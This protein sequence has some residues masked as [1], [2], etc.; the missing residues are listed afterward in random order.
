MNGDSK[1]G[2]SRFDPNFTQNVINAMGPKTSPRMREIM[3]SLTRH[4]H[5]FAREVEL[6]VDE[7]A[8][9][10]QL[11][12]WAGQMSNDRR[13]EGQLVCDVVGLETLVDEITYKKAAEAADLATQS[14]ILGPFF[15]TDHTI[16]KKGESIST[17]TPEDAEVVYLY[18]RVVDATTKKPLAN[19]SVDVWEASTN[20][21]YEQQD[22]NQ[23]KSNL[24]GKFYTDENGEYG[25]Y[26]LRPTPY[27]IPYD[28][29]AGKLLQLLDRHP[30]RPAHIHFIV[31]AEGYKP[32]TT[33]IFDKDSK[34]LD[35]DSVFAVKDSLI[36]EFVARQGDEKAKKELKYDILMAPL[37]SKGESGEA[38]V[39]EGMGR[40]F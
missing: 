4:L 22:E 7:W 10:V 29:P 37:S 32:I 17:N 6:T 2:A 38:L 21:L 25:F 27:P 1:T 20:G 31:L 26:C 33:Q 35:D 34:Y 13:N 40:G 39:T 30:Y 18:G 9:G 15:Q 36:V 11:I 28:G 14:A 3:T 8:E 23:P 19:A 12:N 24:C 5:D 16:R